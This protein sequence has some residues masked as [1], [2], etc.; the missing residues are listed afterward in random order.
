MPNFSSRAYV[1]LDLQ[2]FE[3]I[4]FVNTDRLKSSRFLPP[5][6]NRSKNCERMDVLDT[7][8]FSIRPNFGA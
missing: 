8:K 2:Q 4:V 1:V 5:K 3:N 6:P 7:L